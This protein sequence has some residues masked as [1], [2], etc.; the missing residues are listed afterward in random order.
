MNDM[1]GSDQ[2]KKSSRYL[3]WTIVSCALLALLW[4]LGN[5][6]FW[7]MLGFIS[8]FGFFAY[9]Y[10]P[11]A[12]PIFGRSDATQQHQG[13]LV[14]A[15]W[16]TIKRTKSIQFA[17]AMG[18]LGFFI[19]WFA[20]NLGG[21]NSTDD[22]PEVD[23]TVNTDSLVD[24]GNERYNSGEYESALN[25]YDQALQADPTNQFGLYNK[26]LVY[27]SKK[28]YRKSISLVNYCIQENPDYGPAYYL[29]GDDYKFINQPDSALYFFDRAY[30]M[31]VRDPGLLQNLGDTY[32]DQ[33]E[34]K[35]A[36]QF[37]KQAVGQDTTLVFVYERLAELEPSQAENYRRRAA[38]VKK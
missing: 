28:D 37:Y 1:K 22:Q 5:F 19:V 15:L 24:L 32:Y 8:Y 30:E 31:G 9:Y 18:V 13:K 4:P 38:L 35:K 11:K 17:I 33:K 26:A 10:Q 21:N 3:R 16:E 14:Q 6:V 25:Y 2:N 20:P 12:K 7:I 27:Y 34:N 23:K 29:L 36:I